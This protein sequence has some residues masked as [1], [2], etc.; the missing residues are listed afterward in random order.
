MTGQR[1]GHAGNRL[2]DIRGPEGIIDA[3]AERIG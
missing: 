2:C 3:L 1:M